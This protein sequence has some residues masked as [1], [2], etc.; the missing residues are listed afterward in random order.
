MYDRIPHYPKATISVTPESLYRI[1]PGLATEDQHLF[2][3]GVY[4]FMQ[5]PSA[6]KGE[7]PTQKKAILDS[8]RKP[9]I[10]A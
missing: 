6:E 10:C 3:T 5:P 2:V 9:R 7:K 4:T 1:Y 8:I